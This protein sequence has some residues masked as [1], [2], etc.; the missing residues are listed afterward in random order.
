[1]AVGTQTQ[2]RILDSIEPQQELIRLN[3]KEVQHNYRLL[4]TKADT[5][6]DLL[7]QILDQLKSTSFHELGS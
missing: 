2:S 5:T 1:M 4:A 3:T 6:N 7:A